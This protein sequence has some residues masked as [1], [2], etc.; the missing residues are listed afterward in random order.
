[1]S[2]YAT[3]LRGAVTPGCTVIDIGA[4]PGLFAILA[5]KYGAGKVV[6]IEP[7]PSIGLLHQLA[8]DNGF[9]D[10]IDIVEGLSSDYHPSTK[11]DV[12]ISDLRGALPLF[13]AHIETI[14][15]ARERLLAPGGIL[16]PGRDHL[17]IAAV[18]STETYREYDQPWRTNAY[19][20]DLSAGQR[21]VGNSDTQVDLVEKDL[22]GSPQPLATLDYR[23]ITDP[24]LRRKVALPIDRPGTVHGLL[25]WFDAELAEG[26]TYSNAPGQP[27]SVYRQTFYP[28]EQPVDVDAGDTLHVEIMA[29][30]VRGS[31]VWSWN[32][33]VARG[34]AG[35]SEPLFRQSTF[36]A[37]I[38]RPKQL[39][40]RAV[41]TVPAKTDKM[42][43]DAACLAL[44]DGRRSLTD[45]A[46]AI[47]AE[48]PQAFSGV[49]D[50][51]THVTRLASRYDK[52]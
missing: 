48:F 7:D 4:G 1:M 21:F 51:L 13:E 47:V 39:E 45:I 10:R 50:G 16:I 26:V 19:D 30:L 46:H 37:T 41:V 38:F 22:L 25:I 44:I 33:A 36:L 23:Q 32:T 17:R 52:A 5:C 35:A 28:L 24:N 43:I 12:I 49:A 27:L 34:P 14:K 40:Q 20:V 8:R 18:D 9:A 2:A 15:D 11:A 42:A 3:A 6:A 31:Y 29:N